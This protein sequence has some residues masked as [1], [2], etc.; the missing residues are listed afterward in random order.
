[1]TGF[2]RIGLPYT[3]ATLV[4]CAVVTLVG[5]DLWRTRSTAVFDADRHESYYR[6]P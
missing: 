5:F 1:M 6:W 4:V 3:L 2:M